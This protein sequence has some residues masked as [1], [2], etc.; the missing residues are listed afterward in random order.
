M[1]RHCKLGLMLVCLTSQWLLLGLAVR[2]S[3]AVETLGSPCPDVSVISLNEVLGYETS[4]VI[5]GS[6]LI[7]D[8]PSAGVLELTSPGTTLDFLAARMDSTA[9]ACSRSRRTLEVTFT[10]GTHDGQM[11][12]IA[13]SGRYLFQVVQRGARADERA[14]TEVFFAPMTVVQTN[15]YVASPPDRAGVAIRQTDFYRLG[16]TFKNEEE[17]VDPDPY[18]NSRKKPI[19][20]VLEAR[21]PLRLKNE[22]EE[23]DPDPYR[24]EALSTL[25]GRLVLISEER[26]GPT[27]AKNEEEEVDPDPYRKASA[28]VGR[29][30]EV[31]TGTCGPGARQTEG[32]SG[33]C[34]PR[35]GPSFFGRGSGCGGGGDRVVG[36][37]DSPGGWRL[38]KYEAI[39]SSSEASRKSPVCPPSGT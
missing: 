20:S 22:E 8:V 30:A 15:H 16:L 1:F 26:S 13:S 37:R 14:A 12:G 10:E 4:T 39:P 2:A 34:S 3:S 33:A 31:A 28:P 17:E 27:F 32:L 23:V 36:N 19:F 11:M 7:V 29:L 5:E 18:E 21:L 25:R 24:G 9:E 38:K 6:F 35:G